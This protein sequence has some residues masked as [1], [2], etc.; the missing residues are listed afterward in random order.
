MVGKKGRRGWGKIRP[1]PSKHFQASYPDPNDPN[2]PRHTAPHTFTT[3]MDAEYWLAA[4]RRLIER[5]EWTPPE[6]RT[7]EKKAKG[8]TLA[9]YGPTWIDQRTVKGEPLKPRTKSHYTTIFNE[10]IKPTR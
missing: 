7:A 10:H 6:Q 2:L 3:R 5:D 1:L 8:I 9:E 4:E